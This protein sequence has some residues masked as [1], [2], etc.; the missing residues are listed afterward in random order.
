MFVLNQS[1]QIAYMGR[2]DDNIELDKATSHFLRDAVN[3][4]LAGRQPEIVETLQKGCEIEYQ[5]R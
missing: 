5:N 1:R 4:V 2:I 3:A